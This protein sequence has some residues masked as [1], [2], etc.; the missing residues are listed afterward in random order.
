MPQEKPKKKPVSGFDPADFD[1]FLRGA[2]GSPEFVGPPSPEG[3][4][5]ITPLDEINADFDMWFESQLPDP[6][7]F[8]GPPAPEPF[9]GP[10]PQNPLDNPDSPQWAEKKLAEAKLLIEQGK[11]DYAAQIR[12]QAMRQ[13][14]YEQGQADVLIPM[15]ETAQRQYEIDQLPRIPGTDEP[16]HSQSAQSLL[17]LIVDQVNVSSEAYQELPLEERLKVGLKAG[18][19]APIETGGS[20]LQGVWNLANFDRPD[21]QI[22]G[23]INEE[24]GLPQNITQGLQEAIGIA[25]T[26]DIEELAPDLWGRLVS[27]IGAQI[28]IAKGLRTA[29]GGARMAE[30]ARATTASRTATGADKLA[31][32]AR[33]GQAG[34]RKAAV[35]PARGV[36]GA[37]RDMPFLAAFDVAMGA[38]D[39]SIARMV[40]EFNPDS[41]GA[42]L[43]RNPVV[44]AF[45][46]FAAGA[47]P[48]VA[49][50]M[51]GDGT[52]AVLRAVRSGDQAAAEEAARATIRALQDL[53]EPP[54]LT[55][56]QEQLLLAPGPKAPPAQ[57]GEPDFVGPTRGVIPGGP[58]RGPRAV[59]VEPV[60]REDLGTPVVET[61]TRR[62]GTLEPGEEP[63]R[64][65]PVQESVN[66]A[67]PEEEAA[68]LG[69][70]RWS[71]TVE[72]TR[73]MADAMEARARKQSDEAVDTYR[74]RKKKDNPKAEFERARALQTQAE[75]TLDAAARMRNA[76]D[77]VE[78][79]EVVPV[80]GK[81]PQGEMFD[82][83]PATEPAA[84]PT[85]RATEETVAGEAV[86]QPDMFPPTTEDVLPTAAEIGA[87]RAEAIGDVEDPVVRAHRARQ[88]ADAARRAAEPEEPRLKTV[89]EIMD[90]ERAARKRA[91]T[92]RSGDITGDE[93]T[94][95]SQI[96]EQRARARDPE[97]RGARE[98]YSRVRGQS[99]EELRVTRDEAPTQYERMLA[100]QR[101]RGDEP[102]KPDDWYDQRQADRAGRESG[103]EARRA[104]QASESPEEPKVAPEEPRAPEEAPE[105]GKQPESVDFNREQ[106]DFE[107]LNDLAMRPREDL[108]N[109]TGLDR[110][111]LERLDNGQ[112][113]IPPSVWAL[114]Q[115]RK[116]SNA[117]AAGAAMAGAG[118]FAMLDEDQRGEG[119][120]AAGVLAAGVPLR[121]R[122]ADILRTLYRAGDTRVAPP[123]V[124]DDMAR[125][126]GRTRLVRY[127]PSRSTPLDPTDISSRTGKA[128]AEVKRGTP[129]ERVYYY[130]EEVEP[131]ENVIH[132][133]RTAAEALEERGLSSHVQELEDP[134]A[135]E[136]LVTFEFED[137]RKARWE[138]RE[139]VEEI[140]GP[141]GD[142]KVL[143]IDVTSEDP[144][145]VVYSYGDPMGEGMFGHADLM[146]MVRRIARMYPDYD[147]VES[148]R[149]GGAR[150]V[151]DGDADPLLRAEIKDRMKGPQ[152]TPPETVSGINLQ[153]FRAEVDGFPM[154]RIYDL[155]DDPLGF[156][157]HSGGDIN[158]AEALMIASGF[159]GYQNTSFKGTTGKIVAMFGHLQ[160][161]RVRANPT[162]NSSLSSN[163]AIVDALVGNIR[164]NGGATLNAI[165][166]DMG[167]RFRGGDQD[168]WV[169]SVR[170]ERGI[171][172]PLDAENTITE[173][174]F[175]DNFDLLQ[176]EE[177]N[178]GGWKDDQGRIH[179]DVSIIVP[180]EDL[181]REIGLLHGQEGIFNLRDNSYVEVMAEGQV[182]AVRERRAGVDSFR[183]AGDFAESKG[184]QEARNLF[185][186]LDAKAGRTDIVTDAGTIWKE[187][188][189][190]PW[191]GLAYLGSAAGAAA[192][193]QQFG[194][195]EEALAM[196]GIFGISGASVK[197]IRRSAIKGLAP[198][199]AGM[200]D[201]GLSA[202]DAIA[203]MILRHGEEVEE[204][205][206][207]LTEA[208]EAFRAKVRVAHSNLIEPMFEDFDQIT[209]QARALLRS[210]PDD[211]EV[212]FDLRTGKPVPEPD[213]P[214]LFGRSEGLPA[215]FLRRVKINPREWYGEHL[216]FLQ[217]FF[218][219]HR[220]ALRFI[221]F[222][223]AL[224]PQRPANTTNVTLAIK[225]FNR[226]K[227]AMTAGDDITA[228]TF[229]GTGANK[230]QQE[231]LARLARGEPFF[232]ASGAQKT[233]DFAEALKNMIRDNPVIDL[234]M[235]RIFGA[236]DM[237]GPAEF[238]FRGSKTEAIDE[239]VTAGM[240]KAKARSVVFGKKTGDPF[241]PKGL[242]TA[243]RKI[244][245][246]SSFVQGRKGAVSDDQY[247]YIA[248]RVRQIALHEGLNPVETQALLWVAAK[249]ADEG[250]NTDIRSLHQIFEM[251]P[252]FN[253]ELYSLRDG[254]H[255]EDLQQA[256]D[257]RAQ[258]LEGRKA[259][260]ADPDMQDYFDAR[261]ELE[262]I[263][264]QDPRVPAAYRRAAISDGK[265]IYTAQEEG[266]LGPA[267]MHVNATDQ[268]MKDG[269]SFV[270][271]ERFEAGYSTPSGGFVTRK[272]LEQ[273]L[274]TTGLLGAV[275]AAVGA[276]PEADKNDAA[277]AAMLGM[278]VPAALAKKMGR[279][280]VGMLESFP[281]QGLRGAGR[282]AA[283]T[284]L[285]AGI[286]A[287]VTGDQEGA[288]IGGA[289]GAAGG[290][291]GA[292]SA[293]VRPQEPRVRWAGAAVDTGARDV[294]RS[295]GE[296]SS[297][298]RQR[299]LDDLQAAAE[300]VEGVET[301]SGGKVAARADVEAALRAS[302]AYAPY[303]ETM[304]EQ[305]VMAPG[306]GV[307]RSKGYKQI[308]D[309]VVAEGKLGD[310]R[311]YILA[312]RAAELEARGIEPPQSLKNY[313]EILKEYEGD[314]TLQAAFT[315]L[316][317]MH[318]KILDVAEEVGLIEPGGAERISKLNQAYTPFWTP[319]RGTS[320]YT[321]PFR[322]VIQKI[323]GGSDE[324]MDPITSEIL[325][326]SRM[327]EA[328]F[329]QQSAEALFNLSEAFPGLGAIK[330][331]SP[332]EADVNVRPGD[333]SSLGAGDDPMLGALHRGVLDDI[334][335]DVSARK[336]RVYRDGKAVTF[337][338]KDD[339][340]WDA[341]KNDPQAVAGALKAMAIPSR[342]LREFVTTEPTFAATNFMRDLMHSVATSQ[343]LSRNPVLR[344]PQ[345]IRDAALGI[346]LSLVNQEA[347]GVVRAIQ[348]TAVGGALGAVG[349]GEGDR[350]GGAVV[351]G[352][353]GGLAMG[354]A[355]RV[356]AQRAAKR[357]GA[358]SPEE[359]FNK[360][361]TSGGAQGVVEGFRTRTEAQ[362][363]IVRNALRGNNPAAKN[364]LLHPIRALQEM[365]RA[366]EEGTR[367][368]EW[369]RLM[370]KNGMDRSHPELMRDAQ[371]T[372]DLTV[373]FLRKGGSKS[374]RALSMIKAFWNPQVQGYDRMY[375]LMKQAA[376][377]GPRA[378]A[379]ASQAALAGISAITIPSLLISWVNNTYY[380]DEYYRD[381]TDWERN[382][383]W[384][385]KNPTGPGFIRIPKPFELGLLFG[386]LPERIMEAVFYD[387]PLSEAESSEV[388][389]TLRTIAGDAFEPVN[390]TPTALNPIAE[391]LT[392]RDFTGA[393]IVNPFE[394]LQNKENRFKDPEDA[395]QL[396]QWLSE[397]LDPAVPGT[398]EQW[399][400]V[401]T[402]YT[403]RVGREGLRMTDRIAEVMTGEE[404]APVGQ[405]VSDAFVGDRFLTDSPRATTRSVSRFYDKYREIERARINW[406][407]ET[408]SYDEFPQEEE[409]SEVKKVQK[410]VSLYRKGREAVETAVTWGDLPD[411]W[412]TTGHN[413]SDTLTPQEKRHIIDRL[414]RLADEEAYR[415]LTGEEPEPLAPQP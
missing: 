388:L 34:A 315:D 166:G 329:R 346:G 298:A 22:H 363:T 87:R 251:D 331:I 186:D 319:T 355:A 33:L 303:V 73:R 213:A 4:E 305:G 84:G 323:K 332:D 187:F 359:L 32:F 353:L 56:P 230:S 342:V 301:A 134:D 375:R 217:N 220:D 313:R 226:Y 287:T 407:E 106:K 385:I 25:R 181:A 200:L 260:I 176:K 158:K 42:E 204:I 148:L 316:Q 171:T 133:R 76:A 304:L 299:L 156:Q 266:G 40:A 340:L 96:R 345:T 333:L 98:A 162:L 400:N 173:K 261:I 253:K 276:N 270:D 344:V 20:L 229:A 383:F 85:I 147:S 165:R 45:V 58:D 23:E 157:Y 161:D 235:G 322:Q 318:R 234:W 273:V 250:V 280:I 29:A 19:R 119:A 263:D 192:F 54:P 404:A 179:L 11:H 149:V 48:D 249:I 152:I 378:T 227:R 402:G 240:D 334:G 310:F 132:N 306:E 381:T 379:A 37:L 309:T 392:N 371:V 391:N 125:R 150:M 61:T 138:I 389:E 90:E 111:N 408:G 81:G 79:G 31:A 415:F 368:G 2:E 12:L 347:A 221:G 413:D 360:W 292:R 180:D 293:R 182:K 74:N 195:D 91:E 338:I 75:T 163:R 410:T 291:A 50:G 199:M 259:T 72:E 105:S 377:K 185:E 21:I 395:S 196:L 390:P 71:G 244:V 80:E 51:V 209:T 6:P 170:P 208:A 151:N 130:M 201:E 384:L 159:D 168:A 18:L 178:L 169:V 126:P 108:E 143:E 241:E 354:P 66:V 369:I 122:M 311:N 124:V 164:K 414:S 109:G 193:T 53:P 285:G 302:R 264:S 243:E 115:S 357:A 387:D 269:V 175:R 272:E 191:R 350:A 39:D 242:T 239:L 102:M 362:R 225:A 137:G 36:V 335:A 94:I 254:F 43:L 207:E 380:R 26:G 336:L 205:A 294:P 3:P 15:I 222:Y 307:A 356:A 238:R 52:R 376:G 68:I 308:L 57:P 189:K 399:D 188:V 330:R 123:E 10:Q 267:S 154:S 47:I 86:A 215:Q 403:G 324:V 246:K 265:K 271:L 248:E 77:K 62:Q 128:G 245:E 107:Y 203:Q 358:A 411:F 24:T 325:Y 211:L 290:L 206:D 63:V 46:E 278:G 88:E 224:S 314:E 409:W 286:G 140:T 365:N 103:L 184:L 274:K 398:P 257:F 202:T 160:P 9:V 223:A 101:L 397:Y 289:I 412:D 38:S 78:A 155:G 321:S 370:E 282:F 228:I 268:A 343:T 277:M 114:E 70:A 312:R 236:L 372:R 361:V 174:F 146:K 283:A 27:E 237:A 5:A 129:I 117:R 99:E 104:A 65:A 255:F 92:I 93:A 17:S 279:R 55:K 1:A 339:L 281:G 284:G 394:L 121:G 135:F 247:T 216:P 14:A 219:N 35:A 352:V 233:P 232:T 100:D 194:D 16:M 13:Q 190:D 405:R 153:P 252:R 212:D 326:M 231:A 197:A 116:Q 8:V 296:A 60:A 7:E 218:G 367:L 83:L 198:R 364:P 30:G 386:S 341:Y 113:P 44:A 348:G 327:G 351:G 374:I 136:D 67:F 142:K 320:K 112:D 262:G 41:P 95:F 258:G 69:E 382:A 393:P 118:A 89:R 337:E 214:S 49:L 127:V 145:G 59:D 141:R 172:E 144:D 288:I 82:V 139:P 110:H 28:S 317:D 167:A 177:Y 64:P 297:I 97:L 131:F 275:I 183:A 406:K 120:L 210:V 366:V 373:D 396:G 328:I 300:L 295:F 256:L 349:A 401:L